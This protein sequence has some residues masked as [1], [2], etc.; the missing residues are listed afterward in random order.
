[1]FFAS[2]T[3]ATLD[4]SRLSS[5]FTVVSSDRGLDESVLDFVPRPV[6]A[7]VI[8]FPITDSY[9]SHRKQQD[10][11]L[12]SSSSSTDPSLVFFRQ[13]IGNACGTIGLLHALA[14]NMSDLGIE[15]ETALAKIVEQGNGK[16]AYE[17]GKL[18]EKS[19]QL[20]EIH[21]KMGGEGQT[22]APAADSDVNLHFVAFVKGSDGHVYEL[23]GRRE[24]PVDH[25]EAEDLL[26]G[27]AKVLQGMVEREQGNLSFSM[28][29]LCPDV[30][31]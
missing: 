19:S 27:A 21:A 1:M 7:V 18:L 6:L 9:E 2:T 17:R 11:L 12:A 22:E 29:A 25:G 31:E 30:G 3:P 26:V 5:D 4:L 20:S 15:K 8:L 28:L 24:R 13:T 16:T 10:A 23:D 14:N